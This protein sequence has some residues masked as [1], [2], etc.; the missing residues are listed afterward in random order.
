MEKA[1]RLME[2]TDN[3]IEEDVPVQPSE[4]EYKKFLKDVKRSKII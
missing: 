3:L 1:D 4:K 2:L